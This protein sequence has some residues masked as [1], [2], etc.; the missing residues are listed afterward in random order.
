MVATL[1]IAGAILFVIERLLINK[2]VDPATGKISSYIG[3]D[4]NAIEI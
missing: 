1:V 2:K 3:E 4:E